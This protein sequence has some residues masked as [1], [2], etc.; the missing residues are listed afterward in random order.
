MQDPTK[1]GALERPKDERDILLGSVQAPVSI[2]ATFIP[3]LSW[4]VRNY[5]GE[6][7]FCGEHAATHLKAILDYDPAASVA[8]HYTPRYGAIK[9]K[10]PGSPVCDGYAPDAGTDMRSLFK[11][12]EVLGADTF[13][14]LENDVTLPITTY[15]EPT[16]V[17]PDMDASAATEK[18]ASYAFDALDFESLCQA[19]YQNKAVLL[20]I[21][22]D[23]G[24]WGTSTPTFTT[25]TY[26]HFI[27]AYGYDENSIRIIDSAEPNNEFALKTIGK[28]YITSEFFFESGTA[29][30]LPAIVKQALTNTQP[31]PASV[32][33]ALTSGQLSLA[34]QILNDIEA[35]LSLIQKEV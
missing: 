6:T 2:P 4:L 20:L 26:G 31:V 22:C 12:L 1:L 25:P 8:P 34:E 18:I 29:V 24:F 19:I 17:T 10:T 33:K 11:W 7:T 13:E 27:V 21:K 23:D 5:Q 3:D 16:A 14:P 35:A 28:Q 9:L 32:Q 30:D 15:L